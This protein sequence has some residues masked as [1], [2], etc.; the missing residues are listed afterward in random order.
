MN[1]NGKGWIIKLL[2][3][4]LFTIL[5]VAITTLAGHTV[6]N[7]KESRARDKEVQAEAIERDDEIK[8]EAILSERR[9]FATLDDIKTEQH[10]NFTEI[11]L[12]LKELQIKIED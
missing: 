3:G 8:K 1:N 5:F 9:I 11:L 7:D 10:E 12:S 2:L 4:F 6:A